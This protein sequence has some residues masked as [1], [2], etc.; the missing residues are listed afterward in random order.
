MYGWKELCDVVPGVKMY[1]FTPGWEQTFSG[2]QDLP[3][4]SWVDPRSVC[5]SRWAGR[6][7]VPLVCNKVTERELYSSN[8]YHP[9]GLH[10][11]DSIDQR[12]F[13]P[14]TLTDLTQEEREWLVANLSGQNALWSTRQVWSSSMVSAKDFLPT[15]GASQEIIDGNLPNELRDSLRLFVT[16]SPVIMHGSADAAMKQNGLTVGA[17]KTVQ[18]SDPDEVRSMKREKYT[19]EYW[20]L[21]SIKR[22]PSANW[23]SRRDVLGINMDIAGG[24]NGIVPCRWSVNYAQKDYKLITPG[25]TEFMNSRTIQFEYL[26]DKELAVEKDGWLAWPVLPWDTDNGVIEGEEYTTSVSPLM[27]ILQQ[28]IL[29]ANAKPLV[30]IDPARVL[31][32]TFARSG[33]KYIRP[34][35]DFW[36]PVVDKNNLLDRRFVFSGTVGVTDVPG[37]AFSGV[38][39]EIKT[40]VNS[41]LGRTL[42]YR[43]LSQVQAAYLVARTL[44]CPGVMLSTSHEHVSDQDS[45]DVLKGWHR[46]YGLDRYSNKDK[47]KLLSDLEETVHELA[48]ERVELLSK[49][50]MVRSTHSRQDTK[51]GFY[52]AQNYGD[53]RDDGFPRNVFIP[54]VGRLAGSPVEEAGTNS[55]WSANLATEGRIR[56]DSV[57]SPESP[58]LL[59]LRRRQTGHTYYEMPAPPVLG[60]FEE[61]GQAYKKAE[62][63]L[64]AKT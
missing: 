37:G 31:V 32:H 1:Q 10:A 59:D 22:L 2:K 54:G 56:A 34:G 33:F 27:T 40:S 12:Y 3:F 13:T 38:P 4:P 63:S 62:E 47:A 35:D 46:I 52:Y 53:C 11:K 36:M 55:G 42:S 64:W 49:P 61:P 45:Y 24:S 58:A 23:V 48:R 16:D 20:S 6:T 15:A 51:E 9:L 21:D 41:Y 5:L 25:E 7:V 18:S 26:D 57:Y 17:S 39:V 14:V 19:P 50:L 43:S 44:D 30:M 8:E 29:T 60:D 28:L